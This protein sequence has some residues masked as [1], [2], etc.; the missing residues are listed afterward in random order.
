MWTSKDKNDWLK[1]GDFNTIDHP[2][3][4]PGNTNLLKV[5][6]REVTF[7]DTPSTR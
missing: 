6:R 7:S 2:D 3:E 5:V 1:S 4:L